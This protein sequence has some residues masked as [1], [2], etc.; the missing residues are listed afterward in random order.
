MS[1]IEYVNWRDNDTCQGYRNIIQS[2]K[3]LG[4][5]RNVFKFLNNWI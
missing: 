2:F 3:S 5:A 4:N 1:R